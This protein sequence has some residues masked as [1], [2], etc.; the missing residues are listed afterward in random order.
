MIRGLNA[1]TNV[2]A[3]SVCPDSRGKSEV[4][5]HRS[6]IDASLNSTVAGCNNRHPTEEVWNFLAIFRIVLDLGAKFLI[7][8]ALYNVGRQE[9]VTPSCHREE[10]R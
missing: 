6:C 9:S 2:F 1:K 8:E 10:R 7:Q 5:D 3:G 4:D